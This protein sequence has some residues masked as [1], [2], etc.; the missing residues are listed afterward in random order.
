MGLIKLIYFGIMEIVI[1]YIIIIAFNP[2][3]KEIG[4]GYLIPLFIIV[5]IIIAI[6]FFITTLRKI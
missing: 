1:A 2:L 3:F 6:V 5:L 4:L